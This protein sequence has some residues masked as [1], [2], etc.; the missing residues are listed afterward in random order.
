MPK[1][2]VKSDQNFKLFLNTRRHLLLAIVMIWATVALIFFAIKPQLSPILKLRSN[3]ETER[4]QYLELTKKIQDLNN[5]KVSDQFLK[6]DKVDEVLPSHKPISE[7]L[8]NLYQT[9]NSS[10]TNI[11]A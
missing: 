3:L 1:T 10:N 8:F 5:I 7:L 11:T 2:K 9:M 4:K 6:K